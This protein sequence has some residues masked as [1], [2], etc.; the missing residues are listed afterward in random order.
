MLCWSRMIEV[1]VDL[2]WFLFFIMQLSI[3]CGSGRMR[4]ISVHQELLWLVNYIV[5]FR[6][7]ST[8]VSPGEF[9]V[10]QLSQVLDRMRD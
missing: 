6:C 3:E 5:R 9:R 8:S 7:L 10:V 2:C 4:L 1:V